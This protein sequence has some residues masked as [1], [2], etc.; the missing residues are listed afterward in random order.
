VAAQ[1]D[2]ILLAIRASAPNLKALDLKAGPGTARFSWVTLAGR[3]LSP[4]LKFVRELVDRWLH[5]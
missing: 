1:S 5:D 2:T 3:S 4:G